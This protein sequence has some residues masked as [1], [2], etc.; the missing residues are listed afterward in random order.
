MTAA[1]PDPGSPQA[2]APGTSGTPGA[3]PS[4]LM[5][6]QRALI[7][8]MVGTFVMGVAG[9]GAAVLSNSQAILLDGL[10]S[11]VGF[12]AAAVALRVIRQVQRNP[13]RVRP[14]GYGADESLFTTFRALSLL[15]VV[16]F[17]IL[18]AIGS[19]VGYL[20][21]TAPPPLNPEPIVVYLG[22]ILA[23][24][25]TLWLFH[26]RAWV[27]G[28]K[29]SE[30]LRLEANAAA[31]DGAV[32]AAAGVGLLMIT[33][34]DE[35]PLA[36]I[37]PVG[38][39][40]IVLLLCSM[41]AVRY[42]SD[43]RAGLAE[44]AGVAAPAAQYDVVKRA[45]EAPLAAWGGRLV[46]MAVLKTGRTYTIVIFVDPGRPV[47]A[48]AVD[49]LSAECTTALGDRLGPARII[50]VVSAKGIGIPRNSA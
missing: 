1:P 20:S 47:T 17:A 33:A 42:L 45:I 26:R 39:S 46:D 37:A 18:N 32:T 28:G 16:L 25:F 29:R 34:F 23:I 2:P 12:I 30:I 49:A 15:G 38:D 35:G 5:V 21:G 50:A 7:V 6:E 9:V 27:K 10:F 4:D 11:F 36:A 40:V 3:A 48:E 13:D 24:C 43:F 41:A 22:A 14:F 19:I 44:L 8:S 31:F